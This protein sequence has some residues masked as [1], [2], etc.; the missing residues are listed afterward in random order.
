VNERTS[1]ERLFFDEHQW[2]TVE[3]AMHPHHP[4]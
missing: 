2:A 1:E 3:A 4:D